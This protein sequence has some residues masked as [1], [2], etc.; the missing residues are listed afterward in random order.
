MPTNHFGFGKPVEVVV[1]V[2]KCDESHNTAIPVDEWKYL[3]HHI[4]I[5]RSA[6]V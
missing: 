6:I 3:L 1:G 2:G 5:T 4:A